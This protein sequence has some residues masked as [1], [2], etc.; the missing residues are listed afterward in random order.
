MLVGGAALSTAR[1][2]TS[3][4][5]ALPALVGPSMKP[6]VM[7]GPYGHVTSSCFA[8]FDWFKQRTCP[9]DLF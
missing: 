9:C 3:G 1:P 5:V 6:P 7:I 8:N 2:L 4:L